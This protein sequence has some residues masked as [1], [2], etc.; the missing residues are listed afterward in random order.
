MIIFQVVT[1]LVFEE[2]KKPYT[3]LPSGEK[4]SAEQP[5]RPVGTEVCS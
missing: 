4:Q 3:N 1:S 5:F 2:T